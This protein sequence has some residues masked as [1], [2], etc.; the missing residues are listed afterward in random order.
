MSRR[1]SRLDILTAAGLADSERER[2]LREGQREAANTGR[3]T[4]ALSSLI[5]AA[6]N[7]AGAVYDT[8]GEQAV[9]EAQAFANQ[10]GDVVDQEE[11]RSLV[12]ANPALAERN[13]D[14]GI[15]ENLMAPVRAKAR[16]TATDELSKRAAANTAAIRAKQA[17]EA[18]TQRQQANLET[19]RA[20]AA[21]AREAQRA[22]DAARQAIE[23]ARYAENITRSDTRR[24][25][26]IAREDARRKEEMGAR[27]ADRAES[28]ATRLAAQEAARAEREGVREDASTT[29]LRKEFNGLPEVKAYKEA[30]IAY[31]KL[32]QA[33]QDASAAGDIA[34]IFNFMKTLDPGST[35]REGEFATASNAGGVDSTILNAYN[36]AVDGT[37]LTPEQ[38]T[39]FVAQGRRA[40]AAHKTAYDAAAGRYGAL[41]G[42]RKSSVVGDAADPTA[43]PDSFENFVG[44]GR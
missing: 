35:V 13:P 27:A 23:D 20:D 3:W 21:A 37:R 8:V 42:E 34:L 7:A 18:E 36:K 19:A 15:L 6:T 5:P 29:G 12:E 38:R 10:H 1:S 9:N 32:E 17:A 2:A 14:G 25:E 11:A 31:Q 26:D 41:A 28:R 4:S 22:S 16:A 44:G 40:F 30:S 33:A 24:A 39:S 43:D